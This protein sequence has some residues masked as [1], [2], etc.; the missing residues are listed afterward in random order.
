MS[1][2]IETQ[3]QDGNKLQWCY[4]GTASLPAV[5]AGICSQLLGTL[6]TT[7]GSIIGTWEDSTDENGNH[8]QRASDSFGR[9]TQVVEPS[10][11][12]PSPSMQTTYNYDV[13]GNLLS[14]QQNG[15]NGSTARSHTF[16]YDSLSRLTFA[17]NPE[18]GSVTY[19]YDANDNVKTKTDARNVQ[20]TYSYDGLNRLLS[21]TYSD[22]QTPIS[23]YQFDT[24]SFS[25]GS[26]NGNLIGRM[27]NAWT[28]KTGTTCNSSGPS[29]GQYLSL[30]SMLCYDPMGRPTSAQ[31]QHCVAGVCSGPSPYS[32]SMSYDVAGNQTSLTNSVGEQASGGTQ[33]SPMALSTYSDSA[34]RPCLETS[35]WS[36]S[37]SPNLFQTNPST[38]TPGYWAFGGLQNWYLGSSSSTASTDCSTTPS[39]TVNAQQQFDPRLRLTG[40]SSTGQVP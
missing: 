6:N 33:G 22:G 28:Q 34:A 27:T 24:T 20:V 26:G 16:I 32:L 25:C 10:G 23:C 12:S 7:P 21:K 2:L 3:E 38:S 36:S 39:S 1:R 40:F 11:S 9:L 29:I 19:T 37:F 18:T 8:W 14:A 35:T 15:S 13:L 5:S 30:K 17:Q 4:D 31:Q